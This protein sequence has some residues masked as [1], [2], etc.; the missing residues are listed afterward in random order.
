MY[1]ERKTEVGDIGV[2]TVRKGRSLLAE[3]R[4]GNFWGAVACEQGLGD[5]KDFS[6]QSRKG[7]AKAKI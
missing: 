6:R 5:P 1:I 3:G 2:T 4:C 7:K